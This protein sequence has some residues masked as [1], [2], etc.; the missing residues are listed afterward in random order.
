[1]MRIARF[2]GAILLL[3]VPA[4][5]HVT[6]TPLE[7]QL[8]ATESYAF[9]VPSEGG[10]T[11]TSVVLDVPDGVTIVS[12]GAPSGVKHDETRKGDR[13]VSVTWTVEIKAGASAALS[14]VAKNPLEGSFITWNVHQKYADGMTSDWIGGAGS[15]TPAP[16][17]KIAPGTK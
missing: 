10:M 15:R 3:A 2:T 4:F 11:T 16:I 12:V 5:A 9:R 13:I 6:V 14:F 1:M 17:T 7:S 8:G